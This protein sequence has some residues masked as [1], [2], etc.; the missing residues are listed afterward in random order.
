MNKRVYIV[1]G[2]YFDFDRGIH[3]IG[4]VQTYVYELSAIFRELG[5]DVTIYAYDPKEREADENGCHV[6]GYNI[7]DDKNRIKR[8]DALVCQ[9]MQSI[10]DLVLIDT[11]FRV[12]PK[13]KIKHLITIQHGISWDIPRYRGHS[14]VRMMLAK[15]VDAYSTVKQLEVC[16]HAVCVDH[17]FV[18][19]YRALMEEPHCRFTVIPN[20]THI[21]PI[22]EKP[23]D[24]INIMF[25]RRLIEYRGTRVFTSAIK[26]ILPDY[27]NVYV[28]IAGDGPD[29]KWMKS[30][31][32]SFDHVNFTTYQAQDSAKIHA[33]K[34]IAVVPT[35]GSEGTSLS[36][37]EAMSSQCAVICSDVG[38]MTDIVLDGYNGIMVGAG[39]SESLYQA[40]KSLIDNPEDIKRLSK[41]GYETVKQSF[42]YERWKMQWIEV[43]Q[44]LSKDAQ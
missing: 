42:S 14:I 12:Y 17:N 39:N 22:V 19:W 36:L 38:G 7:P 10:D 30:E 4:G 35:V 27:D 15:A 2:G 37:L 13:S 33:D 1:S 34:H 28:T 6:R 25:A 31:L 20:F 8:L 41:I 40:M 18:N 29:L 43:I 26:R 23:A 3:T 9:E 32:A 16:E 44:G 24:R 5:F 11:H 21:F